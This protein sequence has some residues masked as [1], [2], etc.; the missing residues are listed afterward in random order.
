M[1][2]S[3]HLPDIVASG[4]VGKN[5]LLDIFQIAENRQSNI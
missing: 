1:A 5:A 3:S 4:T 2:T